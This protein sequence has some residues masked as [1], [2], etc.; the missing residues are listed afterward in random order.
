MDAGYIQHDPNVPQGRDGFK[1][2]MS[3]LVGAPEEISPCGSM[4]RC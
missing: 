4:L 1:Q 3:Y 2:Y